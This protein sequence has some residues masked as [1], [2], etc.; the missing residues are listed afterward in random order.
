MILNLSENWMSLLKSNPMTSS[1]PVTIEECRRCGLRQAR[2]MQQIYEDGAIDWQCDACGKKIRLGYL[3]SSQLAQMESKRGRLKAEEN[4]SRYMNE[5]FE[6]TQER[7]RESE[8]AP[9]KRPD[10]LAEF[11]KGM[12]PQFEQ[13]DMEEKPADVFNPKN[14]V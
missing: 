7:M 5:R 2:G 10:V 13:E 3:E 8:F 14:H 12:N 4:R 1:E 11:Y 9:E 6:Y